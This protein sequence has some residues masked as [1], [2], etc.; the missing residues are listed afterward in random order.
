[1][2]DRLCRDSFTD[3][4]LN[5]YM[6]VPEAGCWL[7]LG[8]QRDKGYGY[9]Y[10]KGPPH[11]KLPAHRG[12]YL[13]FNG[14]IPDDMHVCHKCDT[15]ACVNPAHLF[16]GSNLDNVA[17]RVAKGRSA[18]HAGD[19]NPNATLTAAD[20]IAIRSSRG[21][22]SDVAKAFNVSKT[23]VLSIRKRTTWRNIP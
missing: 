23:N 3:R 9:I 7:W 6:P 10:T 2:T 21:S 8:G 16:L 1:M 14:E 4:A 17:D 15:P 18:K 12:F 22:A 5:N 11:L 19:E 13:A 20:V